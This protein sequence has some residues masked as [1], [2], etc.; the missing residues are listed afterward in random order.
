MEISAN[1]NYPDEPQDTVF[2]RKTTKFIKELKEFKEA[3]K[4]QLNELKE[5][6]GLSY[7]QK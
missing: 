7:A 3:I 6:K 5:N 1:E 2:K 4:K